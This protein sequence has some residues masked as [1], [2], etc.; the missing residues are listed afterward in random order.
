MGIS[1]SSP[2]LTQSPITG[3]PTFTKIR[4]NKKVKLKLKLN[5]IETYYTNIKL[6]KI[7]W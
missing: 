4:E 2:G 1:S 3:Q 6:I 5:R 7:I